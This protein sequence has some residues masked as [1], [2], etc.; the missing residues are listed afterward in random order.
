MTNTSIQL[1]CAAQSVGAVNSLVTTLFQT[2]LTAQCAISA[3]SDWPPDYGDGA[4]KDGIGKYDFIVIGAGSAG[5]VVASRLSENVKWKVLVLEA[6]DDPPQESEIPGLHTF[7]QRTRYSWDYYSDP[8]P[9]ICQALG[10]RLC[11]NPRGK[12]IGGTGAINGMVYVKG[13]RQD[14]DDW[15]AAGNTQWGWADVKRFYERAERPVGNTTHPMGYVVLDAYKDEGSVLLN[16]AIFNATAELGVPSKSAFEDGVEVG[17]AFLPVTN[18]HGRRTA[19][20]KTYL[21]KVSRRPNLHVIKN[22]HVH[23]IHFDSS[24]K[25]ATRVTFSLRESYELSAEVRKEVVLSAGTID[26]PKLL[27]LSGVGPRKHLEKLD[28]P[29]VHDMPVGSNL[30]DHVALR[31]HF[32]LEHTSLNAFEQTT[33]IDFL[34]QFLTRNNSRLVNGPS[35]ITSFI[36]TK[37]D[38]DLPDI[39]YHYALHQQGDVEF[40]GVHFARRD[41][42]YTA[43]LSGILRKS[44]F[45]TKII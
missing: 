7:L 15:L 5:S 35:S 19:T 33:Y 21:A 41:Q 22:A 44:H 8:Q 11:Y 42:K 40:F 17:T 27:M 14:F 9:H 24:G 38:S 4:L 16:S 12:L 2:I 34:Y 39:Q 29:V 13:H 6:G 31:V 26:S 36:N 28:I 3:K 20:G 30:R 23:K 32:K 10:R 43:R 1:P 25:R 45:K 37:G 18:S